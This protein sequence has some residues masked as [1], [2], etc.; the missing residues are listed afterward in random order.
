MTPRHS[1]SARR[2][3][4][5][6][7][8]GS[9]P[10]TQEGR[11]GGPRNEPRVWLRKWFQRWHA[12]WAFYHLWAFKRHCRRCFLTGREPSRPTQRRT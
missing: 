3:R 7:E 5:S 11:H 6:S 8:V 4:A 2:V 12:L 1:S 9:L 10:D